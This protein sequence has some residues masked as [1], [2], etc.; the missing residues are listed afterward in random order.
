MR[1]K[2]CRLWVDVFRGNFFF[3]WSC[4]LKSI[5]VIVSKIK[6]KRNFLTLRSIKGHI[7]MTVYRNILTCTF[8]SCKIRFLKLGKLDTQQ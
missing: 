1:K 8:N 4:K 6:D 5:Y 7:D 2:L 3:L